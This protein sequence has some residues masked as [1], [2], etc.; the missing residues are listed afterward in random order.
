[1]LWLVD[2]AESA[3][4]SKSL[5]SLTVSEGLG[6]HAFK[7]NRVVVVPSAW[8][9]DDCLVK[10]IASAVSSLLSRFGSVLLLLVRTEWIP[11]V[12]VNEAMRL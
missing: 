2:D 12:S 6:R 1:M 8:H 11:E 4:A 9:G 3:P 5:S 7:L 10:L